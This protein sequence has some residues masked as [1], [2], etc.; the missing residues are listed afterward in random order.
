MALCRI[1][2]QLHH[3]SVAWF[4][5]RVEFWVS[6]ETKFYIEGTLETKMSVTG[7]AECL[8][9]IGEDKKVSFL[10]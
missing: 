1:K 6:F 2:N 9:A 10:E 3:I 7:K 4:Q 8:L 5:V